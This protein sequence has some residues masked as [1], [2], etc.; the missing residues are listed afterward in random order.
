MGE[1]RSR[2]GSHFREISL[3]GTESSNQTEQIPNDGAHV[4]EIDS[5][6]Y[7][8]SRSLNRALINSFIEV[9]STSSHSK[10][11]QKQQ[12]EEQPQKEKP[13]YQRRQ[14][15]KPKK[16]EEQITS[17]F[18]PAQIFTFAGVGDAE[19]STEKRD[20]PE[21]QPEAE[22][23]E[24]P[25]WS[26][27][28]PT[29]AI[30]MEYLNQAKKQNQKTTTKTKSEDVSSKAVKITVTKTQKTTQV[31]T[32]GLEN[33][34]DAI[35]S[36]T[37]RFRPSSPFRMAMYGRDDDDVDVDT[38]PFEVRD[39][40]MPGTPMCDEGRD[41]SHK[42]SYRTAGPL[43][44]VDTSPTFASQQDNKKSLADSD[45]V[46]FYDDDTGSTL[47]L[48]GNLTPIARLR[49]PISYDVLSLD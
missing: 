44:L 49:N 23:P 1:S 9:K 16:E 27:L 40:P 32:C 4:V 7:T 34:W 33:T 42:S 12:Q 35:P 29:S 37:R 21:A 38:R 47:R 8:K 43:L 13:K 28:S 18:A 20:E 46:L 5:L 36:A 26:F 3:P 30:A 11:Q 19:E 45:S 2:P 39:G 48:R 14:E 10:S 22:A 6:S 25:F 41:P 15:Q 17:T 24:E 31:N